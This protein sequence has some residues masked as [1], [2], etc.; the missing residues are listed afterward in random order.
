VAGNLLL[1]VSE[2]AANALRHAGGVLEVPFSS[3]PVSLHVA[4]DDPGPV[5]P[6][7]RAPGRTGQA[8]GFGWAAVTGIADGLAVRPRRGGDETMAVLLTR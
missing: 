3:A 4:V 7:C 8:G 1:M 2:L 6:R 5:R